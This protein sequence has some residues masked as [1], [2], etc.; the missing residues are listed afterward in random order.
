MERQAPD[1]NRYWANKD[2]GQKAAAII[3][4]ALFGATGQGMQWLSRLDSLVKQDI[5]QQAAE[6]NRKEGLVGRQISSQNNLIA[7]AKEK[8]LSNREAFSAAQLAMKQNYANQFEMAAAKSGSEMVKARAQENIAKIQMSMQKD[9]QELQV[10]AQDAA[11]KK[12]EMA[13]HAFDANTRRM[14]VMMDA[15]ARTRAAGAK[16]KLQLTAAESDRVSAA[17]AGLDALDSLEKA[18]GSGKLTDAV[19]DEFMSLFPGTNASN[20]DQQAKLLGRKVFGGIDGSAVQAS[21][22]EFLKKLQSGVGIQSMSRGDIPAFG[23][24]LRASH[25]AAITTARDRQA[26]TFELLEDK[27]SIQYKKT[28]K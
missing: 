3:A 1:P 9:V 26:G 4:G 23:R 21:D 18:I 11:L 22:Q 16:E 27:P 24:L 7:M 17:K 19:G 6:L 14:N 20:R 10:K 5:E 13:L 8:G 2:A 28:G 12:Q 25:N 15:Q